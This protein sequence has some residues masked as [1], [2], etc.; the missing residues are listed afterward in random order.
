MSWPSSAR[1]LLRRILASWQ[2]HPEEGIMTAKGIFYV[3][4]LVSDLARSKRFYGETLG[5]TL[6]TDE[7]DVAGFSFGSGYLV[8]HTDDRSGSA[9]PYAGG[10]HVAVQVDDVA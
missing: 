8:L 5:W 3:F 9:R 4:A 6:G 1:R 2:L 7:P 10:M